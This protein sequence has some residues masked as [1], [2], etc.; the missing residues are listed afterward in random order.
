MS[1]PLAMKDL[2]YAGA[3]SELTRRALRDYSLAH[4]YDEWLEDRAW[5]EPRWFAWLV[6]LL[7]EETDTPELFPKGKWATIQRMEE[8]LSESAK[9][10]IAER[11]PT[12]HG[13]TPK[14][15]P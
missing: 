10:E 2:V 7:K 15:Q 6:A 14:E 1:E 8:L 12:S 11:H 3:L 5:I 9:A 4:D 13:A